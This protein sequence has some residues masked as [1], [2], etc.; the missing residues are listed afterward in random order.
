MAEKYFWLKLQK[1]FFKR[2]DI[3][4]IEAMENG[5]DY[6][7]FYLKL[8][9]ESVS[10][11]GNLRFSDTIPYNDKMLS[12]IT[13]TD[14]DKVRNAIK[15]FT[16]LQMMEVLEDGTIY[17]AECQ[18]MLGSECG[19]AERVRKHRLMLKEQEMLHCNN[20][21]TNSNTQVTKSNIDIDKEKDI[22]NK[23]VNNIE[24][25]NESNYNIAHTYICTHER[26]EEERQ[27][28]KSRWSEFFKYCCTD[29]YVN[30]SNQII[31][32]I[33]NVTDLIREQGAFRF[34]TKK[35]YLEDIEKILD[36]IDD[37]KMRN[38]T[39]QVANTEE[40]ESNFYIVGCLIKASEQK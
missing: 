8:L 20:N 37:E 7:L 4:I 22:D 23:L 26:T 6:I 35:Y 36:N 10:H 15:I 5:K 17:L 14:I 29:K 1:D 19:S 39:M 30:A 11:N 25:K 32:T 2:H 12:T 3:K 34:N 28:Y 31:D 18:K 40:I 38:I 9:C 21:V 33:L 13:D 24:N 27:L 16:E